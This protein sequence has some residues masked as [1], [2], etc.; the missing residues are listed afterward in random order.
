VITINGCAMR[1]EHEII[2][3]LPHLAE[4]WLGMLLH[5]LEYVETGFVPTVRYK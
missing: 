1:E 5:R 3:E 2:A 4:L